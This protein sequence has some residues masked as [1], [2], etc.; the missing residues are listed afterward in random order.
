VGTPKVLTSFAMKLM[1]VSDSAPRR[2][3]QAHCKAAWAA[4]RAMRAPQAQ[5]RAG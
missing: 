4:I 5:G 1:V 2:A 3:P